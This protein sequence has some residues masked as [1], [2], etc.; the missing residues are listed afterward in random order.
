[1]KLNHSPNDPSRPRPHWPTAHRELV[2]AKAGRRYLFRYALGQ[3]K[4]LL[5]NLAQLVDDP[6]HE[7]TAADLA[8]VIKQLGGDINEQLQQFKTPDNPAS[9]STADDQR[10]AA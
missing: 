1:M 5:S 6:E 7:L 3:E 10:G 4:Q 8:S 2:I 9:T